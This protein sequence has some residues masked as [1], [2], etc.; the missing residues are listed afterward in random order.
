[1]HHCTPVT[2]VPQLHISLGFFEK[3]YI[4]EM[5]QNPKM[6]ACLEK[7]AVK[8]KGIVKQSQYITTALF[9]CV[10]AVLL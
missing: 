7:Q 4:P 2:A 5:G 10:C 8:N 1:M 3:P 6:P 9:L